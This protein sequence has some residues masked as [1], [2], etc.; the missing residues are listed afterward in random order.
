M[1]KTTAAS[2][3]A[4]HQTVP[5]KVETAQGP[6][7]IQMAFTEQ[8]LSAHGG[9]A[10][11]SSFLQKLRWRQALAEAL[12]HRPTSPNAFAPVDIALGFLGGV[13]AGADK[14]SRVGQLC[15]DPA[16]PEILG[17]EAIPSQ[18]TLTRFFAGFSQ[19]ANEAFASLHR[20]LARQLPSHKGGYTL[21][22]D[23][24]SILH[25]E[26]HQEGVRPGYTPRGLKPGHHPLIAALAEPKLVSN[27]WLRSG[28]TV[29]ASNVVNFLQHTL[30]HLPAQ[31]RVGLV[32][33]DAGFYGLE[34]LR[35]LEQRGIDYIVVAKLR[36]NLQKLGRHADQEWTPTEVPGLEVQEV[37]SAAV[38]GLGGRRLIVLR[39]RVAQNA[40]A[41]AARP[42]STCQAIASRRSAPRCRAPF[43][44]WPSGAATMA[45]RM[46]KTGSRNSRGSLDCAA[47]A[48]APSGAPKRP[49]TS[50]SSPTTSA[51]SSSASWGCCK[52]S[53]SPPCVFVSL[54]APPFSAAPPD[55]PRSNSPSQKPSAAGGARYSK[56]SAPNCRPL[57][58]IQLKESVHDVLSLLAAN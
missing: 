11:M 45:G 5:L 12:P 56:N 15:G 38:H 41:P 1:K 4:S 50:S 23:S 26:G 31:V 22:L 37:D 3:E 8:R 46:W 18:P 16:L 10:L 58:A 6:K 24:L 52:R 33:A 2:H 34:L 9:L 25:E 51:C 54:P 36:Q 32:R 40:R 43:R 19:P 44:R 49:A 48:A 13:L 55:A 53:N 14:F 21:D 28:D 47:S 42:C 29:S 20:F 7:S 27:F 57:T 30:T 17:I 35:A 39:H